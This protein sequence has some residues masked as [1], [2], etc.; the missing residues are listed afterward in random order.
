V[1]DAFN[2]IPFPVSFYKLNIELIVG[3]GDMGISH[4]TNGAA[5]TYAFGCG[6]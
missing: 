2:V 5:T 3:A 4:G 6:F 1:I